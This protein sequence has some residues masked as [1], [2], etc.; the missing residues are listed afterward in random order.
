MV[1]DPQTNKQTS[2]QTATHPQ[3]GPIT[4]HCAAANAQCSKINIIIA[5]LSCN[6]TS[7]AAT[8]IEVSK[9]HTNLML[10]CFIEAGERE[11]NKS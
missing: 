9:P 7:A 2:N 10:L 5:I 8:A 3:T 11:T 1:T 6:K 4:I